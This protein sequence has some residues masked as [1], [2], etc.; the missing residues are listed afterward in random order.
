MAHN[1]K[2]FAV[3]RRNLDLSKNDLE[4]RFAASADA[5]TKQPSMPS[6]MSA[7]GTAGGVA[8]LISGRNSVS[9]A[10]P[11]FSKRLR[12]VARPK[13]VASGRKC[14]GSRWLDDMAGQRQAWPEAQATPAELARDGS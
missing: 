11:I 6:T 7:A 8:S 2:H 1:S 9:I 3:P 5:F 13:H 12:V 10:R 14:S 4:A